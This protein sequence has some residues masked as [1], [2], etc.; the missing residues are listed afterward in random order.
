V[1]L[2]SLG[3][4][5]YGFAFSVFVI[6]IGQ[7]GFYAYFNLDRKIPNQEAVIIVVNPTQ[8]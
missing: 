3:A 2:V 5:A 1:I 6:S 7:P 4:Y 8:H